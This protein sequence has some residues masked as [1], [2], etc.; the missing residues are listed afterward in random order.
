[1]TRPLRI[2]DP[3][4]FYHVLSRGNEKRPVFRDEADHLYFMTLLEEMCKRFGVEVWSY[5]L[6]RNHYHLVLR[7][8]ETPLSRAMQWLGV[9]YTARHNRR[10]GRCGHLFQG[11]FKAFLVTEEDYLD[12]LIRYVHR[13]PLR[14]GIVD[15]LAAYRWSSYGALGYGK[16]CPAWLARKSVLR[17]YGDAAAFRRAVQ[18]YSEEES[19]LWEDLR[20]GAFLGSVEACER[21]WRKR[22]PKAHHEIPASRVRDGKGDIADRLDD[23]SVAL[24]ISKGE[25]AAL[26]RP[27][28]GQIRPLR[29][30]LMYGLWSDAQY[31]LDEIGQLFNVGY[32]SVANARR[33]AEAYLPNHPSLQRNFERHTA[34]DK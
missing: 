2:H 28:R 11:R 12:R 18:T 32:T 1:M 34:N 5:V 9:S 20:H 13:N 14:A 23:W 16:Q 21:L 25:L 3:E 22:K 27:V 31:T 30:V 8:G 15:R 29:D 4:A 33:R 17:L 6:M 7:V 19:N 24:G 26:R 10:H